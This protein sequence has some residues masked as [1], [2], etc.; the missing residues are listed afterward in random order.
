M[1]SNLSMV[2]VIEMGGLKLVWCL[3]IAMLHH[4]I[5][6]TIVST[7]SILRGTVVAIKQAVLDL[8]KLTR[9]E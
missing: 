2:N 3:E 9:Y 1:N 6:V 4:Q 5:V 8:P 7:S